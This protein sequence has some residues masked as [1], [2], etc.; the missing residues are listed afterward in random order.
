MHQM[1]GHGRWRRVLVVWEGSESDRAEHIHLHQLVVLQ[2]SCTSKGGLA[3]LAFEVPEP[4]ELPINVVHPVHET[5]PFPFQ[6]ADPVIDVTNSSDAGRSAA[7]MATKVVELGVEHLIGE[8][9]RMRGARMG[10][11]WR[12]AGAA[13]STGGPVGQMGAPL[14]ERE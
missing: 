4:V 14:K 13:A 10:S 6:F 2:L 11:T 9:S 12:L 8:L 7:Q 1:E 3:K 5:V